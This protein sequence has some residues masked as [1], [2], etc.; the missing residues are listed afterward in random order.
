VAEA[1]DCLAAVVNV[2][3]G[4]AGALQYIA[5]KLVHG[6]IGVE[7]QQAVRAHMFSTY[8]LPEERMPMHAPVQTGVI[9]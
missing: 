3:D 8:N 9:A 1:V 5:H 4:T 7:N 2:L 6:R